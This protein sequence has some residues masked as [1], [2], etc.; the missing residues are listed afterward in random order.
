MWFTASLAVVGSFILARLET[1]VKE[2][3]D[4]REKGM[5]EQEGEKK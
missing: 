2:H 3:K 4:A 1:R 5:T